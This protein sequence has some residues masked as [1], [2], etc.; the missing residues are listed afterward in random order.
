MVA[1]YICLFFLSFAQVFCDD[2]SYHSGHG[3]AYEKYG[4][5]PRG[6]IVVV[7]PDGYVSL[8]VDLEDTDRIDAFFEKCM[9]P[10]QHHK[11]GSGDAGEAKTIETKHHNSVQ[12]QVTSQHARVASSP[13][14][15]ASATVAL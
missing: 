7:R 12:Q 4:I 8:L 3:R 1:D 2:D 5:S 11:T 10:A 6:A 14:Q 13:T 9:L 15:P